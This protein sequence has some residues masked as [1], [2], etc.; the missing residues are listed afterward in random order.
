M[1]PIEE[2]SKPEGYPSRGNSWA[3]WAYNSRV[4]KSWEALMERC[5]EGAQRCYEHLRTQPMQRIPGRVFPLRHAQY[6]KLGVWEYELTS[7]DRVYYVPRSED[8][9]VL[10]YYAGE[11][12]KGKVPDPPKYV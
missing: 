6:R 5:P 11:H 3:V 12:P 10:V 8:R 2:L 7:G 4:N 1:S 9:T